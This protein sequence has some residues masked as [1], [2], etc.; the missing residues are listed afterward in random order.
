MTI[1]LIAYLAAQVAFY[2]A[3][4]ADARVSEEG[5]AKGYAEG[6]ELAARLFGPRPAY[7][8]LVFYN[9]VSLWVFTA[10]WAFLG[11]YTFQYVVVAITLA[12]AGKHLT[13]VRLWRRKFATNGDY[14]PNTA[15]DK[16]LNW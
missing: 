14:E 6:N 12:A 10:P 3:Q 2:F 5:F 16:F 7:D 15:L 11:W 8:K 13:A 9:Y 1:F 4:R